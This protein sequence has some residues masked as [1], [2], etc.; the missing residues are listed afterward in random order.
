MLRVVMTWVGNN[1]KGL[2]LHVGGVLARYG[3]S[4]SFVALQLLEIFS[5]LI[6]VSLRA[7]ELRIHY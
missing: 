7:C 2:R 1:R 4:P 5:Y 6:A 3:G